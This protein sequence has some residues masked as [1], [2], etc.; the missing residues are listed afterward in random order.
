MTE[1]KNSLV[2]ANDETAE[3]AAEAN[4]DS[5]SEATF[6]LGDYP[7]EWGRAQRLEA[8][9]RKYLDSLDRE[10]LPPMMSANS[11]LVQ[12]TNAALIIG[13]AVAK[14][15]KTTKE[16]RVPGP[17]V[18]ALLPWQIAE[19]A[20]IYYRV[21]R[22]SLAGPK[23]KTEELYVYCDSGPDIGL[24]VADESAL[25]ERIRLFDK[26]IDDRKMKE[27]LGKLSDSAPRVEKNSDVDAVPCKSRVFDFKT[28]TQ[29]DYDPERDVFTAKLPIDCPTARPDEPVRALSDGSEWSFTSWMLDLFEPLA[30]AEEVAELIWEV[31]SAIVR[32]G[33]AWGRAVFFHSVEGESGKGT[34]ADLFANL[35]GDAFCSIPLRR[36]GVEYALEPLM[37]AQAVIVDENDVG[38]FLENLANFKAAVTGDRL[39]INRKYKSTVTVTFHGLIVQCIN[40]FPDTKDKS[41]SFYRRQL[42]VPFPKSFTGAAFPE[43]KEQFLADPEVLEFVL[44]EALH[45]D[46]Y[47]LSEPESCRALKEQAI[48]S[49]DLVFE[50]WQEHRD[51]FV[52]DLLPFSFLFALF[53]AW[54]MKVNPGTNTLKTKT[55]KERILRAVRRDELWACDDPTRTFKRG[56]R[57]LGAEPLISDYGLKPDAWNAN[58]A[59]YNGIERRDTLPNSGADLLRLQLD[60]IAEWKRWAVELD[61]VTDPGHIDE[62]VSIRRKARTA[63]ACPPGASDGRSQSDMSDRAKA[64][65]R[66][67][68]KLAN[69][70]ADGV[71]VT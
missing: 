31:I 39:P 66:I 62:H 42:F 43:I 2:A 5:T 46:H 32:P 11:D 44:W 63:C 18:T 52:W 67:D 3:V 23:S 20:A 45:R 24:Y 69:L 60:D 70:R 58:A 71:S 26:E 22:I 59:T 55:F 25:R 14:N 41:D 34:L 33:V 36:W 16:L 68:V 7:R 21:R 54:R 50:F 51:Q 35:L 65:E 17:Q 53:E 37:E 64:S 13:W 8:V 15:G 12:R 56:S 9:T 49:N 6:L 1:N 30:D 4:S 19:L 47:S 38:S 10:N 28:K 57:M 29:R 40:D 48:E 61:G 27:I